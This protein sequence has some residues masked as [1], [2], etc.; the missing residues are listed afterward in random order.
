MWFLPSIVRQNPP[1][2]RNTAKPVSVLIKYTASRGKLQA[3][4]VIF[5]ALFVQILHL[6]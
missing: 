4:F 1:V 6:L 5:L 2:F 3:F